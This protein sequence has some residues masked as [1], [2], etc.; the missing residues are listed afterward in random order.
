MK[1][2]CLQF[3]NRQ[4]E[5]DKIIHMSRSDF[6]ELL[7][8]NKQESIDREKAYQKRL[9]E[10]QEQKSKDYSEGKNTDYAAY[11]KQAREQKTIE[12][13]E[14]V[15][16][17]FET[18]TPAPTKTDNFEE[19]LSNLSEEIDR[20]MKIDSFEDDAEYIDDDELLSEDW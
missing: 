15:K 14:I 1:L 16:E 18:K 19:D 2:G 7:K 8:K 13:E 12:D 20:L 4:R 11:Y 9:K 17:F 10:D 3:V 6:L 5:A